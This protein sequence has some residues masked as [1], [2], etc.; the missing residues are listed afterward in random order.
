[1]HS[2]LHNLWKKYVSDD[3]PTVIW[4]IGTRDG[5]DSIELKKF[6]GSA[7]IHAFEPTP[8]SFEEACKKL[9]GFG[10]DCH[11]VA[12]SDRNGTA[13]FY[14]NDPNLSITPW[15]DGNQGANSLYRANSLYPYE[16]YVQ[17]PHTVNLRTGSELILKIG[18]PQP[19]LLWI[20]TQ[21]SELSVL[22]GFGRRLSLAKLIFTELSVK[23]L[24]LE[25]PGALSVVLKLNRTGFL[26]I[27]SNSH[28]EWQFDATFVNYRSMSP[29]N[30]VSATLKNLIFLFWLLCPISHKP[31][32]NCSYSQFIDIYFKSRFKN[33]RLFQK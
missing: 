31:L 29:K 1:M 15:P 2:E 21:G 18:L 14:L 23:P 8:K 26:Y 33:L 5:N 17:I 4:E 10:I 20:D 6:F 32:I 9:S 11:Q 3:N 7:V 13:T 25:S 19:E 22:N 30:R 27:K 28:G 16:K 12:V 24:Y